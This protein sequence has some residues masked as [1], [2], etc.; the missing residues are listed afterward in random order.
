MNK[1][2][3]VELAQMIA[4]AVVEALKKENIVGASN[5]PPKQEKTAYAKTEALLY[6]Y[7]NFKRII[8]ERM[9]EIETIRTYGVPTNSKSIVQYGSGG[10]GKSPGIV[11]AEESVENAIRNVESSV[12]HTVQAV[13][14]IDKCMAT[15]KTDPYYSILEMRYFEG[16]T[17]EDIA[18][19]LNCSQVTISKNK[20]RLVKELALRLFP[21]QS[22]EEMM[23]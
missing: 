8:K 22:I 23:H 6:N 9:L 14:L 17:Q 18:M 10:G 19:Q 2:N 5:T 13:A 3:M 15:L 12:E 20:N 16:R 1:E 4:T 11:L 7:N 21:D